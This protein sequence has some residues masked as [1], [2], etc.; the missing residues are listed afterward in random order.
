M[1]NNSEKKIILISNDDG[2]HSQGIRKL[3][4]ALRRVGRVYI[5][6]PDRERS[7]ASHSLTL[8]RPLR[9]TEVG[10]FT[11]AVDGTPTD[12]IT[13]AVNGI[14]PER[15]HIIVSGI[16]KGGNLGEDVSYSGTVAAAMEGTLLDIPSVA[17]SL[18]GSEKF[19]FTAAARFSAK[20]ARYILKK[21]L[22]KD[23][24][25]N[26]NV[27]S[28]KDIRGHRITKQGKRFFSD[29]L[30]EKIDPRGKKYYWIGGEMERWE[31]GRESDF[32]AVTGG[33]V[34]I[35]PLHLD[36]TNYRSMEELRGWKLR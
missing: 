20:L 4:S 15:P 33:H 18:V 31:G 30:V 26:V 12:C 2:I 14:L 21:G 13:I 17:V 29:V 1:K 7:A 32:H 11:Y 28:G 16:N 3:A 19:D 6:A 27:P 10:P 23:T 5:V 9:V 36:M 34:S 22:P 25:L 24:F 8:H 35:T